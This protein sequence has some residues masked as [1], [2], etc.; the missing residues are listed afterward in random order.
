VA[1]KKSDLYG[2][3]W[4]SCD[5]L[6]GSMDA[7]QYK[8]YV[9]TL[10]FLKYVSDKAKADSDSLIEVPE[11]CSFDDLV[12]LKGD[13][14]IGEKID[15]IISKLANANELQGVIDV[16]SFNDD[17]KLGKGKEMIDT[18]SKLIAIFEGLDFRASGAQG[19]DLL[20]D[21]YEYLM[22]H[23]AVE[24][25]KSKGQFY[26]PAEVSRILAKVVGI[27][28]AA[29]PNQTIYDPT[30]GSGSLLLK[31][32]HEAPQGLTIYGQEK[33][34][35]TWSLS[36]MNMV[37]HG[38]ETAEIENGDVISS[39]GFARDGSLKQHD[40]IVANPPFS[41]KAWN[42]GILPEEDDFKRFE[43][44]IPPDKNG[45][46]A[47]L[48]HCIKSLKSTGKAAVILPHGVLFR[49]GAE[50][51]IRR[52]LL[53]LGMIKGVIG[54]PANLFYGTGI[55]ACIVVIDKEGADKRDSIF[56][57]NASEGFKKDG[58]KNRLREQDIHKIVDV[59]SSQ[60]EVE[61]FS[62]K[63]SR[64]EIA[65][66]AND[67][68]LNLPRY[69]D[70][71]EP[72]DL[73]DLDA[74]LNGGIPDHDLGQLSGYW[75]A[76]PSLREQL[77]E[78]ERPGYSKA[79]VSSSEVQETIDANAD[80]QTFS[81]AV[82]EKV[83]EWWGAH[84]E[85]L[86][87]IDKGT[88]PGPIIEELSEDLLDRFKAFQL[89]DPY[90]IYEQL[91]TYWAETMQDDIYLVG[92]EGWFDA[93]QPRARREIGKTDKGKPK[94]EEADLSFGSGKMARKYKMDL[95]PHEVIVER[96]FAQEGKKLEEL[97]LKSDQASQAVEDYAAEHAVEEGLLEE[98]IED[99]KITKK[100]LTD[101][102][103]E[104]K[105]QAAYEDELKA[106]KAYQQ[107]LDD[108]AAAKKAAKDAEASLGQKTV[109]KYAELNEDEVKTLVVGSKWSPTLDH[110]FREVLSG[111]R[112]ILSARGSLLE[113]RYLKT[114]D[115]VLGQV[116]ELTACVEGHLTSMLE[117]T[118]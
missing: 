64:D 73:Q 34:L 31:A 77:F 82:E 42:S 9:L 104:T 89:L 30:C 36:R 40:F 116:K 83:S 92:A 99:G 32:A 61:G 29:R 70:A 103:K 106:L 115:E 102:I 80:V 54:L 56:L 111:L 28:Q 81:T 35:A 98:V 17:A 84:K 52:K 49:G 69:I 20:G 66:E 68:N 50:E 22:R 88:L 47:F 12:A 6:R 10:L 16:T 67:Y 93:A 7:S 23:F 96:F 100:A 113:R 87:G 4:K 46:Y 85:T 39:P 51:K 72:E 13:A 43:I 63:V 75:E 57:I 33:D 19:D 21:A 94:Y 108:E 3:L 37:L 1:I 5:E 44:G 8:D 86:E 14:E 55:P 110:R 48:L 114:Q 101:R 78:A 65:N 107:L 41:V 79:K 2:M 90:D 59:F 118:P 24:S 76:F 97:R 15:V 109:A 71:S 18:L 25:G 112:Q 117:D 27:N 91:M 105:G 53:Q 38:N 26:T 95:L 60:T 45:D 74:H 58:P 11:G 62:R